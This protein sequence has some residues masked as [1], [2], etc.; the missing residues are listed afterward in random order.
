MKPSVLSNPEIARL[1]RGLSLLL[2]AG[3]P[4][5]DGLYLLSEEEENTFRVHLESMGKEMDGG[6]SLFAAME[7]IGG[8]PAYVIGMVQVGERTGRLEEALQALA[9]YYEERERMDAR[10]KNALAYPAVLLL[11]MLIV[12]GVL[13]VRVLPVFDEV[14]ASLGS[15]LTGLAGGLLQFGQV[16][17]KIMPFLCILLA[18][19]VVF[20]LAFLTSETVRRR[21][22][23]RWNKKYGD[24]GI[25]RKINNARFAEALAMGL[26]S[27]LP[28][29]E[30]VELAGSLMKDVPDA[31]KRYEACAE[32]LRNGGELTKTLRSSDALPASACRLL[33][34]GMRGGSG[35]E[36][37]EEIADRLSEEA[38]QAL[39]EKAAKVEPTMVLAASLLVGVILLSVMLPL[40]HI[41]S[42][43][44]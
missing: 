27:G 31:A 28:L 40:M 21:I 38:A 16:L 33:E 18:A 5:G 1:C 2:H 6:L 20:L 13:L 32:A 26:R 19:A 11:L 17:E 14:Y 24:S 30:A 37:M 41:M 35:D 34:L 10:M 8:F 23:N 7:K 39:E 3:I 29:E 22:G 36:V 4:L 42:A 12:I 9:K 15:Q 43:I 25:S 44:G